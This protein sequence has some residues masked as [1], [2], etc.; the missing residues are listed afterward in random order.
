[1]GLEVRADDGSVLPAGEVG[2]VWLRSAAVMSGYWG[3]P[4]ASAEALV[5]GWLRTGDL[6]RLDGDGVL[7]LAG[8]QG[9]MYIRG[10]YNVFPSE[11]AAVLGGHPA[12]DDVVVVARADEVMGEVGVAVVVPADATAPPTLDDLRRFAAER[13]AH[14][15]LPEDLVVVDDLPLT[16]MQKVDRRRLAALVAAATAT[17]G[18]DATGTTGTGATPG[19]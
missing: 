17:T 4:A 16:A 10:G 3:D 13:L 12:V 11:V 6:G 7:T 5:G 2:A 9:E 19:I 1:M 15:K 14:H 8:R 18:T